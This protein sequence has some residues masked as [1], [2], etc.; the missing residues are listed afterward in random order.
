MA[1]VH[2]PA[3]PAPSATPTPCTVQKRYVAS[4]WELWW[5]AYVRPLRDATAR[6]TQGCNEMRAQSGN[7][8]QWLHV[9]EERGKSVDVR[10]D[11]T[12]VSHHVFVDSCSGKETRVPIEPLISFLR[13]PH[14]MCLD[15]TLRWQGSK[16][17]LL[18]S[19]PSEAYWPADAPRGRARSYF[20]DLGAS[21]YTAGI[22]GAS[23]RWFVEQY[24]RRGI[25]FDRILAWEAKAWEPGHIFGAMP[26]RVVDKVSYFNVPVNATPN[27]KHNPLRVLRAIA[28]PDDFVVLKIDIDTL[29]I[30]SALVDQILRDPELASLIDEIYYEHHVKFSP[31][32]AMWWHRDS[33]TSKPK[34]TLADSYELFS[35]LRER[36][37]R[38]HSW[39]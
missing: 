15:K 18:P 7:T 24:E 34:M 3:A 22:G 8:R 30:E 6:W 9:A 29:A 14:A 4:T 27:G 5:R 36:G 12:N 28:S 38:A 10:W 1:V 21:L 31:M 35:A 23:Q 17:Y 16:A 11:H 33:S 2:A 13:H 20:F 37:I 39:V 19:W 26:D 32:Y 25:V